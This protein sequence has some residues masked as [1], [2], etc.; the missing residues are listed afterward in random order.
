MFLVWKPQKN[1]WP[2]C[3]GSQVPS[4]YLHARS[5][6]LVFAGIVTGDVFKNFP[7]HCDVDH[8]IKSIYKSET[9]NCAL[10]TEPHSN[11]L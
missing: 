1:I 6:K 2:P 5:E 7:I 4:R 3:T 8:L 11:L 9:E 10:V